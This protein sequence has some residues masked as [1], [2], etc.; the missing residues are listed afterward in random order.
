MYSEQPTCC[1]PRAPQPAHLPAARVLAACEFARSARA[2][3]IVCGASAQPG[4]AASDQRPFL[5]GAESDKRPRT[6][7]VTIT[8]CAQKQLVSRAARKQSTFPLEM[9]KAECIAR[10]QDKACL[11]H[12][13]KENA[14]H[15]ATPSGQNSP[16]RSQAQSRPRF[17]MQ[18]NYCANRLS[19]ALMRWHGSLTKSVSDWQHLALACVLRPCR[20]DSARPRLPSLFSGV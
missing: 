18:S 14:A 3:S 4:G 19:S 1:A 9:D 20:Q 17:G 12:L 16:S 15:R 8:T 2:C 5:K 11:D 13:P 6:R 7:V 10:G